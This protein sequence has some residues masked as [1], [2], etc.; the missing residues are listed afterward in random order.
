ML[1]AAFLTGGAFGAALTAAGVHQPSVIVAQMELRDFRMAGMFLTASGTS[2]LLV[3]LAKQLSA[4]LR[5]ALPPRGPAA[6]GLVRGNAA[7]GALLGVGIALSGTCPSTVFAQLG[8]LLVGVGIGSSSGSGSGSGSSGSR[9][10]LATLAGALLGGVAWAAALRPAVQREAAA[11]RR[12]VEEKK[13]EKEKKEVSNGKGSSSSSSSSSVGGGSGSPPPLTL[14]EALGVPPAVAAVG[15]AASFAAA[16]AG[17]SATGRLPPSPFSLTL[18]PAAGL[19]GPVAGGLLVAAAQL[20]SMASRTALLGTSGS[21][22]EFGDLCVRALPG[23]G[24][25]E[26][27]KEKKLPALS[28]GAMVLTSGMVA[29][30]AVLSAAANIPSDTTAVGGIGMGRAL[31]GGVLL[32]VGSRL[33]GGCTSGHGISGLSLLSVS[34]LVSVAAMCAGGVGAGAVL[35][36]L[37]G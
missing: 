21:F 16:V 8:S 18:S 32:T 3:T 14:D 10:V 13:K 20:F 35:A 28:Y 29:G 17:L 30:A 25:E 26:E 37:G 11:R 12:Q 9:S 23:R 22:E 5:A 36:R 1:G 6:L 2:I 27:K 34:S 7:G 31:L 33:A 19:V 4:R 24:G 15:V